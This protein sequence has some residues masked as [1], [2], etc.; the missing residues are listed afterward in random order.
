MCQA[1]SATVVVA[2]VVVMPRVTS[3]VCVI[4]RWTT[5]VEECTVWI[6]S[7]DTEVPV[8][9]APVERTIEVESVAISSVLPFCEDVAHIEVTVCPVNSVEVRLSVDAK[10]VVEVDLVSCLVLVVSEVEL[11]SHLISEE[12]S[13]FTSLLKAHS[14]CTESSCEECY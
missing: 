3:V 11:I 7:E 6:A 5:E 2:T 1:V 14:V 9:A 4:E 12:Q 10:K 8:T 13:L